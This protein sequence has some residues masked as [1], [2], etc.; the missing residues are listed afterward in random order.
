MLTDNGPPW[1]SSEIKLF[2]KSRGIKHKKI[3]PLWPRANGLTERFMKNINKCIRASLCANKN[4]REELRLMLINY[5]VTEHPT[6][7][8]SPSELLFNRK[9][10]GFIPDIQQQ[11]SPFYEQVR[12][13]QQQQHE[14]ATRYAPKSSNETLKVGDKVIMI[15]SRRKSKFESSFY[16]STFTVLTIKGTMITV[17]SENGKRYTRNISFFRKQKGTNSKDRIN[18]Q[19]NQNKTVESEK[20]NWKT[21]SKRERKRTVKY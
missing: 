17:E 6:T 18:E 12:D 20:Q 8:M 7:G 3:T 16:N 4:W 10:R 14:R 2:F 19:P 9:V 5:R 1:N 21:Y 11:M 15:R 13:T